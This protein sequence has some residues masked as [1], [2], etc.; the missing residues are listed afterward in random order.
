MLRNMTLS[1]T[2]PPTAV[3]NARRLNLYEII[4]GTSEGGLVGR[5]V[6]LRGGFANEERGRLRHR[7]QEAGEGMRAALV[8]LHDVRNRTATVGRGKRQ[9]DAELRQRVLQHGLRHAV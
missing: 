8:A 4:S 5:V 3:R 6:T 2:P 7:G 9:A 1:P